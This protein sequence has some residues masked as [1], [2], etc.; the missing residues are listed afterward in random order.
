LKEIGQALD[1]I[2]TQKDLAQFLNNTENAQ[3]LNGLVGDIHDTL[4]DYQVLI[5]EPLTLIASNNTPDLIAARYLQQELPNDCESCFPYC[6][7]VYH[8][9]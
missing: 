3:K 1:S 8:N 5:S 7:M 2:T 9:L 4:M 6:S